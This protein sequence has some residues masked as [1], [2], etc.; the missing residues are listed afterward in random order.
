MFRITGLFLLLSLLSCETREEDN[1]N[2]ARKAGEA[3]G[4]ADGQKQGY[5]VGFEEGRIDGFRRGSEEGRAEALLRWTP[6]GFAL[7]FLLGLGGLLLLRREAI[8]ESLAQRRRDAELARA[9]GHLPKELSAKERQGLEIIMQRRQA[10]NRAIHQAQGSQS[11]DLRTSLPPQLKR[12]DGSVVELAKLL[13]QLRR[14]V[15][16]TTTSQQLELQL[17]ERR[18]ELERSSVALRVELEA[19]IAA[20]ERALAARQ[21]AETSQQRCALKLETLTAF[22]DH[23]RM[24]IAN[25]QAAGQLP[26]DAELGQELDTLEETVRLTREELFLL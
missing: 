15:Q 4:F 3:A 17:E 1:Y 24:S 6:L 12:L 13:A 16:E 22:L 11:S 9:L 8:L 23:A 21:R 18:G 5:Q 26:L 7:G 20:G 19:A 2:E 25:V 14:A 10:L